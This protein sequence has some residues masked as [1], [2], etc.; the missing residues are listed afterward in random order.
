M[1]KYASVFVFALIILSC[2]ENPTNEIGISKDNYFLSTQSLYQDLISDNKTNV[3]IYIEGDICAS[4]HVNKIMF[5]LS[6][7]QDSI[8]VD[9]PIMIFHPYNNSQDMNNLFEKY[10]GDYCNL[11]ISTNDSIRLKNQWMKP[12]LNFYGIIINDKNEIIHS[13]FLFDENFLNKV[14]NAYRKLENI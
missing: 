2:K 5:I 1:N 13:C 4:C 14:H 3:I 11:I 10:Y 6:Y 7:M 8:C 12:N 9:K